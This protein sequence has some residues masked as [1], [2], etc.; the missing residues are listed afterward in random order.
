MQVAH[1]LT[2]QCLVEV[3]TIAELERIL[4]LDIL[5]K[6]CMLGINNRDL[7]TF[8]VDLN[9]N[10]V[11]MD[12]KAGQEAVARGLIFAGESGI[13]TPEH[14]KFVQVGPPPPPPLSRYNCFCIAEPF[15]SDGMIFCSR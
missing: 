4:K 7:E 6:D 13:F 10:K 5:D 14:V 15:R 1:K 12:S 9:N 8:V 3:H 11:I 2:L